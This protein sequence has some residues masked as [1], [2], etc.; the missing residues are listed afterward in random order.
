MSVQTAAKHKMPIINM[1]LDD[2]LGTAVV[3]RAGAKRACSMG[4]CRESSGSTPSNRGVPA[5]VK[6]REMNDAPWARWSRKE[7]SLDLSNSKSKVRKPNRT[8]PVNV[9]RLVDERTQRK[10][11]GKGQNTSTSIAQFV[12][13]H[14]HEIGR[15]GS[16]ALQKRDRRAYETQELIRLGCR[17]PKREKMPIALLQQKRRKEKEE[18]ARKKQEDLETGMLMRS[19]RRK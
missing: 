14:R 15:F 9:T 8:T 6:A 13:R 1:Q 3:R 11:H 7:K 19:R 18:L 16:K 5:V 17:P 2:A 10:Q 4:V 12:E